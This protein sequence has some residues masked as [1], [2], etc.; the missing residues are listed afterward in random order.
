MGFKPWL[1]QIRRTLASLMPTGVAMVRVLQW[2]AWGGIPAT[3]LPVFIQDNNRN[4]DM[5]G[6]AKNRFGVDSPS[7][8]AESPI[9]C[10]IT[11]CPRLRSARILLQ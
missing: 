8:T 3:V 4:G 9:V 5:S 10:K 7:A 2:V 1:C 11:R 6:L